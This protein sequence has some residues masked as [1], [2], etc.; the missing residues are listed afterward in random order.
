[1]FVYN[2]KRLNTPLSVHSLV[3]F[4]RHVG[5]FFAQERPKSDQER[6]KSGQERPKS[7]QEQPRATQEKPRAAK[8]ENIELLL[9]AHI[10][11]TP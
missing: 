3:R 7:G 6:P 10:P 11:G 2:E 5:P 9:R 4:L 1:M 8:S